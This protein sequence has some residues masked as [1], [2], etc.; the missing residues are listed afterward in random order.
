MK[1]VLGVETNDR[2]ENYEKWETWRYN[3]IGET[4]ETQTGKYREKREE[5]R[6]EYNKDWIIVS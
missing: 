6:R 4:K 5:N 3:D 2:T 1:L